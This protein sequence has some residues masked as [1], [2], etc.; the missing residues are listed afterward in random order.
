[1]LIHELTPAESAEVLRRSSV[2][3]LGCARHDQPYVVPIHFSFDAGR[4]CV[5]G[6]SAIG[7][8]IEWMRDNPKVC[9]E[10][11]EIGDKDHWTTV[12]VVGRYE[13]IHNDPEQADARQRAER[14][15]SSGASGGSPAPPGHIP[16]ASRR[17]RLPNPD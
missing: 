1:M 6:F 2:G 14:P 11:E 3:R 4:N 5:Y 17:R 15:S 16:R 13:E 8:K 10:V 9:L 7:Q 12:L